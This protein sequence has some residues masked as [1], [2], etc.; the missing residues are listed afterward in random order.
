MS[1][2]EDLD[3]IEDVTPKTAMTVDDLSARL[4]LLSQDGFGDAEVRFEVED[5]LGLFDFYQAV[6]LDGIPV[7]SAGSPSYISILAKEIN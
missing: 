7:T 6:E 1:D 2:R 5:E 4:Y 3:G